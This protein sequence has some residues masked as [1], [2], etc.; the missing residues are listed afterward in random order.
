MN[1]INIETST[2]P[3]KV[4]LEVRDLGVSLPTGPRRSIQAVNS[5]SLTVR[6]GERVGIVGESGS[7]KSVTVRAV[8][9]L[10]PESKLVSVRGSIRFDERELV[11][12]SARDW[13][14]I[15]SK[16]IGMIFQDPMSYLNPTMTIGKQVLESL[17]RGRSSDH[18]MEAVLHNMELAGLTS[19]EELLK[20]YP[21]QLSGG[22]RQRVLIAIALAKSPELIIADEPTTALDA[23]IQR[24]VLR[25][26][27]ESVSKLDTSLLLITHDLAVVAGM[28]DR[29]YVMFRGNVVEHGTV[30]EIYY[31]PQHE[32]T[33]DL[34]RS[35]RSFSDDSEELYVS[36]YGRY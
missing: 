34:L 13:R 16:K 7:G 6:R 17:Q 18:S 9:G 3:A 21:F 36:E 1:N 33:K 27:D 22:M 11:G 23:T 14:E 32:Y 31:N 10:L 25:S 20:K 28:C 29:V 24:K 15:R 30:E 5:V 12:A 2:E 4:L 19:G 8:S 26:L 35:V